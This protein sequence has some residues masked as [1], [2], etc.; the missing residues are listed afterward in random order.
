MLKI[1]SNIRRSS[2]ILLTLALLA[3]FQTGCLFFQLKKLESSLRPLNNSQ[4]SENKTAP[5]EEFD[6][7]SASSLVSRDIYKQ[8]IAKNF[9]ALDRA[10]DEARR[11]KERLPGGYWKI[12][13]IY[14]GL[15]GVY[16]EYPGQRVTDEMWRNHLEVLKKWKAAAPH[17]ITARVALAESYIGY[18]GFARGTGY[19]DT[20]SREDF[21][22]F[23]QRLEM[24]EKELIEAQKI[25]IKCPR[26]YR[27]LLEIGM[28]GG[29]TPDEFDQV[30]DEAIKFEPNYLQFYIVKATNLHPKW[31]GKQGDWQQF[32][33]ELPSKL[34]TLDTDEA[35]IIYFVVA[36]DGFS[37]PSTTDYSKF[38]KDRIRQGFADI[39]RKY[40]ED[41]Y[42]LNQFALMTSAM[43]DMDSAQ[44]AFDRIGDKFNRKV[45]GKDAFNTTKQ[46]I[47]FN[48]SR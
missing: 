29:W 13:A 35:N 37:R 20:V 30:F 24:A 33:D 38:S 3:C 46:F 36:S 48:T 7:S 17:S 5:A 12:D 2:C 14:E 23:Y 47:K 42:R 4:N 25:N 15:T 45:W 39:E 1:K 18:G 34:A 27:E 28:S 9:E 6:E 8:F 40:G 22:I 19:A 11:K 44:K 43:M 41:N 32:V 16:A 10:A 21:A 26:L 31:H